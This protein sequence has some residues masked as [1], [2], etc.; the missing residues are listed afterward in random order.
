MTV[1]RHKF[2][3]T[4][5][6]IGNYSERATCVEATDEI[7]AVKALYDNYGDEF[8][9][10]AKFFVTSEEPVQLYGSAV[11]PTEPGVK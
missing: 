11:W 9:A 10:K 3:V 8:K 4:W 2:R 1:M 6:Y 7:A 5:T